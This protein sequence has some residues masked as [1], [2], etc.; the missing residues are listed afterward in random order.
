MLRICLCL[1]FLTLP[2]QGSAAR[3]YAEIGGWRVDRLPAGG[4]CLAQRDFADGTVLRL[5]T[6]RQ[7]A[8]I[9]HAVTPA[10]GPLIEGDAYDFSY[11]LDGAVTEATGMG[12]YLGATPG[13][14]I[15]MTGLLDRLANTA[16]LRMYFGE[17]EVISA[18]LD[19]GAEAIA[20][21]RACAGGVR[22]AR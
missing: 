13:V 7:G 5:H 15:A 18:E 20:A 10:W 11:D 21:I 6:D 19:A 17:D 22:G 8:G 2:A 16:M 3:P 1:L 9:I 12:H 14:A 4:G